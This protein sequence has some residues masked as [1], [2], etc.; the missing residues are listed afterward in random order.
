MALNTVDFPYEYIPN[1]VNGRP[2]ALGLVYIGVVN[3]DPTIPANQLPVTARQQDGTEVIIPQPISINS[4]GLP[5]YNGQPVLLLVD[6]DYSILIEDQLLSQTYYLAN[7]TTNGNADNIDY[8]SPDT[9]SIQ[10]TIDQVLND[11]NVTYPASFSSL[12]D[13]FNSETDLKLGEGDFAVSSKITIT[14]K[15]KKITGAN[16]NFPAAKTRLQA[17]VFADYVLETS[18]TQSGLT[19]EGIEIDCNDSA[20]I[21]GAIY[22]KDNGLST[23]N[24]NR[25]ENTRLLNCQTTSATAARIEGWGTTIKNMFV[26]RFNRGYGLFFGAGGVSGTT[27]YIER[28]YGGECDTLI[29]ISATVLGV[30]FINPILESATVCYYQRSNEVTMVNPYF[31]N[32]NRKNADGVNY[33]SLILTK[34]QNNAGQPVDYAVYLDGSDAR[35][36]IYGGRITSLNDL[37]NSKFLGVASTS[38]CTM[39]NFRFPTGFDERHIAKIGTGIIVLI[40][41]IN[42]NIE[43]VKDSITKLIFNDDLNT[44]N[45]ENGVTT[46]YGASFPSLS[47]NL[48]DIHRYSSVGLTGLISSNVVY[49]SQTVITSTIAAS[50]NSFTVADASLYRIGDNICLRLDTRLWHY[51]TITNIVAN[52]ITMANAAPSTITSGNALKLWRW[53]NFQTL[54]PETNNITIANAA[55]AE[56]LA[57]V[58]LSTTTA[59]FIKVVCIQ[60]N[61]I[62]AIYNLAVEFRNAAGSASVLIES[63]YENAFTTPTFTVAY[64][65]GLFN[66][67]MLNNAAASATVSARV[68]GRMAI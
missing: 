53:S 40:E 36:V 57:D 30:T 33:S 58:S 59:C 17:T 34:L 62:R 45:I 27:Q 11:Q 3:A 37:A 50:G 26:R 7:S 6:G 52:T 54:T 68:T 60:S 31:E 21:L 46:T 28:F 5:E 4:G 48:G 63:M 23:N 14:R 38:K 15:N 39:Y 10:T 35:L 13:A 12:S 22:I 56:I 24:G 43:S 32:V 42:L 9:N 64:S 65:A 49:S 25:I 61:I 55:S 41:P 2:L 16:A 44:Y 66:L 51:S 19:F 29:R 20:T 67:T 8:Q 18:Q 47:R 1:P